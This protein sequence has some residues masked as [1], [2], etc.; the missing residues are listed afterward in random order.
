MACQ[1]LA[2]HQI[3]FSSVFHWEKLPV[4]VQAGCF[5]YK[6]PHTSARGVD[7]VGL[8]LESCETRIVMGVVFLS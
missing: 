3:F 8:G 6:H 4:R 1:P 7:V 5:L 2:N